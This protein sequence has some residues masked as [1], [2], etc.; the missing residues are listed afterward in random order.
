MLFFF[1]NN[2]KAVLINIIIVNLR[3]SSK[4]IAGDTVILRIHF[5]KKLNEKIKGNKFWE[6]L[7]VPILGE[8]NQLY[9]A[10]GCVAAY[11]M[12]KIPNSVTG[13]LNT[14]MNTSYNCNQQRNKIRCKFSYK[15]NSLH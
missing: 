6:F 13:S 3:P 9:M 5:Q 12:S 8:I 11:S 2:L 14:K 15:N 7:S 4:F 10:V 1:F